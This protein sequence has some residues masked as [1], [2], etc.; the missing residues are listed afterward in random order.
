MEH[1]LE[2]E[3]SK[4]HQRGFTGNKVKRKCK[5][6]KQNISLLSVRIPI[7]IKYTLAMSCPNFPDFQ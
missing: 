1:K 2:C 6:Q 3:E 4:Y 7:E 5:L